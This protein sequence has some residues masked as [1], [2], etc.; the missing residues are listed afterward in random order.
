MITQNNDEHSFENEDLPLKRM[1]R[2][3]PPCSGYRDYWTGEF[4]CWAVHAESCEYCLCTYHTM[5]GLIHPETGKE[6]SYGTALRMYG[7]PEPEPP[8]TKFTFSTNL[9]KQD[10]Q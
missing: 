1:N 4:D 5:G 8:E 3:L 9:S 2:P 10:V 6:M 7:P